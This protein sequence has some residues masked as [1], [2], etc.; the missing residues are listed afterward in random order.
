MGHLAVESE[1]HGVADVV[2]ALHVNGRDD[3]DHVAAVGIDMQMHAG[4]HHFRRVHASLDALVGH[5][6]VLGTHAQGIAILGGA[7]SF[8]TLPSMSRLNA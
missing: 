4:T 7:T 2:D 1:V 8:M 5:V 6:G 3:D